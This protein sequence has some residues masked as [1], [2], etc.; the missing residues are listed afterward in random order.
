MLCD[1]KRNILHSQGALRT[2][3][4][5]LLVATC[6]Y[7]GT[8]LAT[9]AAATTASSAQPSGAAPKPGA[10]PPAG[11]AAPAKAHPVRDAL[12]EKREAAAGSASG[13]QDTAAPG[14][15]DP[16]AAKP[17]GEGSLSADEQAVV[18]AYRKARVAF[19]EAEDA[20]RAAAAKGGQELNAAAEAKQAEAKKAFATAREV[21]VSTGVRLKEAAMAALTPEMRTKV[22]EKLAELDKKRDSD[23]KSRA[24]LHRNKLK[25][26]HGKRA[27]DPAMQAEF[28]RHAWRVARLNR[29]IELAEASERVEAAERARLLLQQEETHHANRLLKLSQNP[30]S[31]GNAE[32]VGSQTTPQGIAV[33]EP[34][35]GSAAASGAS[36]PKPN[37]PSIAEKPAPAA[38]PAAAPKEVKP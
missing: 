10:A 1:M 36:K 27:D 37:A 7:A 32:P 22:S 29:L 5:F 34:A 11:A 16:A 19:K 20:T 33:G 4:A 9:Q 38:P 30:A 2:R 23:R 13:A 12:K 18:S 31:T 21:V 6:G 8:A 15:A 24:D 35:P 26:A 14:S 25:K 3:A 17:P 28:A